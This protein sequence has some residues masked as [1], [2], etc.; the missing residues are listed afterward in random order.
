MARF[1]FHW[2]KDRAPDGPKRRS[3][4]NLICTAATRKA[5]RPCEKT[6]PL[7]LQAGRSYFSIFSPL[8]DGVASR[9]ETA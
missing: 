9:N 4:E 2:G 1:V 8:S 6:A 5:E 7:R 3:P